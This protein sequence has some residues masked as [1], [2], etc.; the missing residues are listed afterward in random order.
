MVQLQKMKINCLF[1]AERNSDEYFKASANENCHANQIIDTE[2]KCR[3]AAEV[4]NLKFISIYIVTPSAHP[5]GCYYE[6]LFGHFNKIT[7]PSQ[8]NPE[9]F[10]SNG[11]ICMRISKNCYYH[12]SVFQLKSTNQWYTVIS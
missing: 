12:A 3:A 2:S 6:E 1:T 7:N 11:G 10:D 9:S 4:L 5:A 8:T